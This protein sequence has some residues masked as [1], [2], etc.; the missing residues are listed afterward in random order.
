L[1]VAGCTS[2]KPS[3]LPIGSV[4]VVEQWLP[5]RFSA[6]EDGRLFIWDQ[7]H[8]RMAYETDLRRGQGVWLDVVTG[9]IFVGATPV[10]GRINPYARHQL[11]FSRA[12]TRP[13]TQ[14]GDAP[15]GG[16]AR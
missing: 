8:H 2:G 5:I 1:T 9:W 11:F 12:A 7:G 3:G 4:L 10:K 16:S 15:A 6:E 13:V 14:P